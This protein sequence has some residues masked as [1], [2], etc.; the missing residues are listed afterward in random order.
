MNSLQSSL[1]DTL[2][3]EFTTLLQA[4][5]YNVMSCKVTWFKSTMNPYFQYVVAAMPI[6]R[7]KY[8]H[9]SLACSVQR[10]PLKIL[11]IYVTNQ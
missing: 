3:K 2:A 9:R 5:T 8:L 1:M 7:Y 10:L 6:H 11:N 4:R